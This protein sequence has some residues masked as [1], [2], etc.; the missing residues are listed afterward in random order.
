MTSSHSQVAFSSRETHHEIAARI[1]SHREAV[2]RELN[3]LEDEKVI[4][5]GR[6]EIRILALDF[7]KR[8]RSGGD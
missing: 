8:D 5:L 1:G 3:R 2:T 4:A 6:R 7:L